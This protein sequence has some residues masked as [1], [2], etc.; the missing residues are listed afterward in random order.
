[1]KILKEKIDG[2][3]VILFNINK[4]EDVLYGD[5]LGFYDCIDLPQAM[6][7]KIKFIQENNQNNQNNDTIKKVEITKHNNNNVLNDVSSKN[8]KKHKLYENKGENK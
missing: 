8:F 7:N 6:R 1:M 4:M 3:D 2:K 5:A